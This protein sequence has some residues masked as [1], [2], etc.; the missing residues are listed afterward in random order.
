V[1]SAIASRT[2]YLTAVDPCPGGYPDCAR[3]LGILRVLE[4]GISSYP[5]SWD[6]RHGMMATPPPKHVMRT[7]KP[8]VMTAA[9][10]RPPSSLPRR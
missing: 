3:S 5:K 6:A 4:W 10:L 2:Y 1:N 7:N 9:S 8:L